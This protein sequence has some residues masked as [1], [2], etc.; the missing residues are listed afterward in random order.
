MKFVLDNWITEKGW[1]AIQ[2]VKHYIQQLLDQVT[3]NHSEKSREAIEVLLALCSLN[4]IEGPSEDGHGSIQRYVALS[5][6]IYGPNSI[7]TANGY[8]LLGWSH[9]GL[10]RNE[11]AELS[12]HRALTAPEGKRDFPPIE[13][14]LQVLWRLVDQLRDSPDPDDALRAFVLGVHTLSWLVTYCPP[15]SPSFALFLERLR[16]QFESRG[17]RNDVWE[18]M[19]RRCNRH[20]TLFI[21]FISVLLEENLVSLVQEESDDSAERFSDEDFLVKGYV[22]SGLKRDHW[23]SDEAFS[24]AFPVVVAEGELSLRV[25]RLLAEG[26]RCL[27][28]TDELTMGVLIFL[29]D[30]LGR[31]ITAFG[32]PTWSNKEEAL[33]RRRVKEKIGE[34]GADSAMMIAWVD[35]PH[36]ESVGSEEGFTE[37]VLVVARDGK[38]YFRGLQPAR[39]VN[40]KYVFHEPIV[41]VT[42]DDWFSE[43]SFPVEPAVKRRPQKPTRESITKWKW[44]K[45]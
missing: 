17:Y 37:A 2:D 8:L 13:P 41:T 25:E 42:E 43:F 19:M 27:S 5:E 18:W 28:T 40:G 36:Q 14:L 7:E 3:T 4:P 16:P 30:R 23:A 24:K 26:C 33:I 32:S 10:G 45:G 35:L 22:I 29:P 31:R 15:Q 6:E 21:G 39:K 44:K 20:N 9:I 34:Y 11:E 38:S 1:Q 12:L